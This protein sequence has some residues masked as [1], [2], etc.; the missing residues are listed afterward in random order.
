MLLQLVEMEVRELLDFYEFPGDDIPV[1]RGSALAAVT[2]GDDSIGKDRVL[3]LMA[4]VDQYIPM[5]EVA[6]Y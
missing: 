2:D 6:Q 5:P 3:E 1:I 4:E